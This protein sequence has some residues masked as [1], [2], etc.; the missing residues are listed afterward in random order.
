MESALVGVTGTLTG[1]VLGAGLTW[2]L[3]KGCTAEEREHQE[4]VLI[5]QRRETAAMALGSELERLD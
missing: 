4:S 3:S 5:R 2:L 1:T